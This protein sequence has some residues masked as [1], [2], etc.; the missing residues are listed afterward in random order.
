MLKKLQ[1]VENLPTTQVTAE[2]DSKMNMRQKV[3]FRHLLYIIY[4]KL[5]QIQKLTSQVYIH[6]F[7]RMNVFL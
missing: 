5:S 3:L 2:S 1:T 4:R 7:P 6:I